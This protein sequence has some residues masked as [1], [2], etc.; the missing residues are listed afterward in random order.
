M[1]EEWIIERNRM[2]AKRDEE[3]R[4]AAIYKGV[5][6]ENSAMKE[7]QI[8][9]GYDPRA[10]TL[11]LSDKMRVVE[12]NPKEFDQISGCPHCGFRHPPDGMCV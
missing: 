8:V 5:T 12:I 9:E 1:F 10:K 7:L 4:I 6:D 3:E 2:R 11:K